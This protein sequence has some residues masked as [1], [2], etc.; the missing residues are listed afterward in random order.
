MKQRIARLRRR[1]AERL[2]R[3]ADLLSKI[4]D[5]LRQLGDIEAGARHC[6]QRRGSGRS[7]RP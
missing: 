1:F 4:I 3:E 2:I 7:L 6:G 5:N